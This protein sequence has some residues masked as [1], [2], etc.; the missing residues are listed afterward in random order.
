[1][2]SMFRVVD[3]EA[4]AVDFRLNE[5][6]ADLDAGW[7]RRNLVTK[8]RQ[9]SGISTYVIARY[10]AKCL[11]PHTPNRRCV[12]ISAEAD[13]TSRLLAR[14]RYILAHLKDDLKP[15]LR[16]DSIKAITFE[17]TG[18]S[19]WIGTAGSRTFGRGDTIT[20]LH[21]S[22]A[23]FYQDAETL[24]S[25]VFPAAELGEIT[26]ESTGNGRGNWFH[27]NAVRAREGKGFKLFFY[28]WV[29]VDS[30][31]IAL[32]SEQENEFRLNLDPE[33]EEDQLFEEGISLPQL[34]WRRERINTD[35]DG[36]LSKFKENYP[37]SFDE[38]FQATGASFFTKTLYSHSPE[39]Q[40]K[41]RLLWQLE[42]HPK[43][44]RGYVAGVD[45]SGGV[46][47]DN[48]VIELFDLETHEQVAE[49]ASAEVA[50][51]ELA[52]VINTLC[53]V[54]NHAYVNVERNNHGLTTL[55]I[56][57]GIY[58]LDRL[59][60]GTTSNAPA[61]QVVLSRLTNYGTY[62]SETTRGLLIGTARRLLANEYSIHSEFLQSELDTFSEQLNGKIE[63]D[64]GCMDDRVMAACHALLVVERA[65]IATA[66]DVSLPGDLEPD[67][68][69]FEAMFNKHDFDGR[70]PLTEYG[71]STRYG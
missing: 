14:A 16:T 21:L 15:S 60:R 17:K 53:T 36:D 40:R 22:E 49:W 3:R 25:G 45:V 6:Q 44:G 34:R 66:E 33:I 67:P 18:S 54:F 2:E 46:G 57:V 61:S 1:M 42:G 52:H 71:I 23:A 37:R 62:T 59:H 10:V 27:R 47:R 11:N 64:S 63:A 13:A 30:C 19:F 12:I 70:E 48:S 43:A 38:C 8:I 65:A 29:G 28:G 24:V 7:S 39:W 50:P 41:T 56:L 4:R 9:H 31:S 26:V 20:D 69:S 5:A 51:D 32:T 58:P 55:A 35:Y 68:F